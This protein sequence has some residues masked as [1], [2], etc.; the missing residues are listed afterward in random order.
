MTEYVKD[1]EGR[2]YRLNERGRKANARLV[3]LM[4]RRDRYSGSLTLSTGAAERDR[5]DERIDRI[6]GEFAEPLNRSLYYSEVRRSHRARAH[7]RRVYRVID[8]EA[9]S[10]EAREQDFDNRPDAE[11][12]ARM[13]PSRRIEEA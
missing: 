6:E 11:R 1:R 13:K 5:L 2:E 7:V 3:R 8:P 10:A 4:T 9:F 12:F